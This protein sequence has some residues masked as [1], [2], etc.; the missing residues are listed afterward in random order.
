MTFKRLALAI[1]FSPYSKNL[2]LEAK[3]LKNLFNAKL[4]LIHI[5]E[6]SLVNKNKMNQLILNCG[7]KEEDYEINWRQG[8]VEDLIMDFC[9]EK[10]IDLLIA[11]ALVR[12]NVF[13]YY[14]G[15]V[16]RK[17]MRESPSSVLLLTKEKDANE[18]FNKICVSVDFSQQSEYA[19][20]VAYEFSKLE[21][22]ENL[23]L[24]REFQLPAF[25]STIFEEENKDDLQKQKHRLLEDEKEKVK[26]F[27]REMNLNDINVNYECL[28]G[29][30]G[31]EASNWVA[32]NKFDLF[33][34]SSPERKPKLIDRIFQH[35]FEFVFKELPSSLLIVK[36]Q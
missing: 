24:I 12:E 26:I 29:K 35:D 25:S 27:I 4:F 1:S 17:L 21:H 2:L 18:S 20:K 31:W 10:Q 30:Q 7:L 19:V 15:S 36:P 8:D 9:I 32:E 13:K 28:L 33:V 23:T 22:S 6:E 3:R 14:I 16:A 34:I 11:G 5:G